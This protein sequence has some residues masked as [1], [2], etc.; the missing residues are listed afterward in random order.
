MNLELERLPDVFDPRLPRFSAEGLIPPGDYL[1][2]EADFLSRFVARSDRRHEIFAGWN[3]HREA[4]LDAGL[5]AETRQLLN[6]SFTTDKSEPGDIDVAVEV[7]IT[8]DE[9]RA[10][11]PALV[12]L[13]GPSMK[14]RFECDAY[15]ILC[16]PTTDPEYERVTVEAIRYWTKWFARTRDGRIKGRIWARTGGL[17]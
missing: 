13:A 6:G 1:P 4:L 9:L 7:P 8:K 12:L 14:A 15:A 16:L 5:D 17:R 3:R 2:S 11:S 10:G